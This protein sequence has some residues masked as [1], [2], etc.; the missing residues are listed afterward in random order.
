MV[1]FNSYVKLP[2]GTSRYFKG[3]NFKAA[4]TFGRVTYINGRSPGSNRW[5]YCSI[6]QAIFCG[7]IPLHRPYIGLIYG[8]YLQSRILKW[9]LNIYI[10]THL[11]VYQFAYRGNH[12]NLNV[13]VFFL[14]LS[15]MERFDSGT[16]W[17][18]LG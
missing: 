3:F 12:P 2:E 6:F 17:P 9:P 16:L 18:F 13:L 11:Y 4:S 8:R 5:R 7:D 1:I 10:Y 14:H 15:R